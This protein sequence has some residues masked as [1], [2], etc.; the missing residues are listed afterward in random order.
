MKAVVES[1]KE[2]LAQLEMIRDSRPKDLAR[3]Q[4]VFDQAIDT[5]RR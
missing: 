2:M 3:Y 4:F 5:T 1:E